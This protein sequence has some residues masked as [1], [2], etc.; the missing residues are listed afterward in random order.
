MAMPRTKDG[1]GVL[2]P[3]GHVLV[4]DPDN[5]CARANGMVLEHRK[6]WQK[7][8]GSC[9]PPGYQLDHVNG[10][11]D[12]QRVREN[13]RALTPRQHVRKTKPWNGNRLKKARCEKRGGRLKGRVQKCVIGKK[14]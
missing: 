5:P 13:L 6:A 11:K 2:T 14:R 10:I 7:E 8:Y 12:D 3:K 9:P 4:W 1:R